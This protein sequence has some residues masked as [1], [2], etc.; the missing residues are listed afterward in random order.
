MS[1]SEDLADFFGKISF[2]MIPPDVIKQAKICLLDFMGI[3]IGAGITPEANDMGKMIRS[4]GDR[5]EASVLGLEFKTSCRN[6]AFCNGVLS[7]LLE[8][9]DGLKFRGIH[10]AESVP[11]AVLALG[12]WNKVSGKNFLTSLVTG[13]EVA[14]RIAEAMFPSHFNRGY[15]PT[16]TVGA[17]GSAASAA[18]LL[19]LG[20]GGIKTA[21][22]IVVRI[23]PMSIEYED[24]KLGGY[25]AKFLHGAQAAKVGVESALMAQAGVTSYPEPLAG[26]Q[27]L[28]QG[29]CFIACDEPKMQQLNTE[30]GTLYLMRELYFK[31][32]P[33]CRNT[34]GAIEMA[35]KIV[36]ENDISPQDVEAVMVKTYTRAASST[37]QNYTNPQSTF[38]SCQFSIPYVMAVS[39]I[40]RMFGLQQLSKKTISN[41]AVHELAAKV[42]VLEDPELEKHFPE[43][44]PTIVEIHTK[45]GK[46]FSYRTDVFKGDPKNPMSEKEFIEKF[47]SLTSIRLKEESQQEMISMIMKLDEMDDISELIQMIP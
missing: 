11:P 47:M 45:Y 6:A 42:K 27:R 35:I 46:V 16:G 36:K 29:F 20:V 2:E 24:N 25:T 44:T 8:V 12:E 37:G 7:A 40:D 10:I 34:H 31:P 28:E 19:D 32:Y 9:Q 15:M 30:L 22:G 13:Y 23:L 41:P 3:T 18:K 14:G 4:W 33:A 21:M 5:E 1:Y 39:I 38:I 17:F 26:S 43:K